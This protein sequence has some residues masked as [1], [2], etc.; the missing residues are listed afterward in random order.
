[1]IKVCFDITVC[2]GSY[3]ALTA[4]TGVFRL[5]ESIS[6]VFTELENLDVQIIWGNTDKYTNPFYTLKYINEH[7]YMHKFPAADN[8]KAMTENKIEKKIFLISQELDHSR[9][10][11]GYLLR[12][13]RKLLRLGSWSNNLMN[14]LMQ[15]KGKRASRN[16]C[17]FNIYHSTFFPISENILINNKISKLYTIHD[18]ITV[19][20]PQYFTTNEQAAQVVNKCISDI[21][22]NDNVIC[23]SE[24]TKNDLC[25]YRTDID[26]SRVHVIYEA[27]SPKFYQVK[28]KESISGMKKK[29][30]IPEECN[31]CLSVGT[32]EP[33][34][35]LKHVVKSFITLL[36]QEKINDLYL[37]LVGTKGWNF[38]S[39]FEE[40]GNDEFIK[41]RIIFTG[42]VPD[43]DLSLIYSGAIMFLY[44][45]MYEGFGLPPLEA[46]QCG[47]P[48]IVS[49]VSS[50]PEVVGEAGILIDPKDKDGLCDGI[51]RIYNNPMLR[52]EL[53]VKL[54]E[55][56]KLFSWE[57]C[58]RET[59]SVYKT[60][61][62]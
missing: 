50:L 46:M 49:N 34:K 6:K 28:D 43:E 38:Q 48:V 19:M 15:N 24:S 18:L 14:L 61:S 33:R 17:G 12:V 10:F 56:S 20:Y 36:K 45:S 60:I 2:G 39:I 13:E 11:H 35:N 16:S 42:Y 37:V 53:S 44:M 30:N 52:E 3:S 55:R 5:V 22:I 41:G 9:D 4:K 31:Y 23:V 25:N 62:Q 47:T 51:L 26:P 54:L 27:A 57:K 32:L 21:G 1:M 29:Y 59:I 8:M 40:I 58:A 7:P